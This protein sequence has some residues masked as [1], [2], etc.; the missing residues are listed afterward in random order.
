MGYGKEGGKE[1]G[2]NSTGAGYDVK[3]SRSVSVVIWE[4]ELGDDR[5]HVKINRRIM[6]LGSKKDCGYDG[7]AYNDW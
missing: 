6:S 3:V 4:Q 1:N 2:G 7:T 5:V